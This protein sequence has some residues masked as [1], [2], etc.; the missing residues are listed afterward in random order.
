MTQT[1]TIGIEVHNIVEQLITEIIPGMSQKVPKYAR[2][3]LEFN[4]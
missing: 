3:S 4:K 2:I 1:T